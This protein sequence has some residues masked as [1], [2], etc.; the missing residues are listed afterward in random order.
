M[1]IISSSGDPLEGLTAA[2]LD[3]LFWRP[4]RLGVVSAWYGHVPFAQWLMAAARPACLVELGAH[5]GVS[6]I[7]FCD[8][9]QRAGVDARCYAVDTWRG[10]EH[11]GFY[12]D[13]IY[14]DLAAFHDRHF[15]AFSRLM[16]CS[17]DEALPFFA[18]GSID[19]LH[20]DGRHRY[21]DVSHDFHTW[22][23]KLSPRAV[24]L[25]HD[26]N[27]RA[28]D[29]G[30]WRLWDELRGR[31]EHFEFLHSHGLGV[32][33]YGP[34]APEA[35]LALCRS[36]D[37]VRLRARFSLLGE[38]WVQD[39]LGVEQEARIAELRAG[40]DRA[41]EAMDAAHADAQARIAHERGRVEKQAALFEQE[42]EMLF[43][44]TAGLQ[45]DVE[46]LR[47]DLSHAL[48]QLSFTQTESAWREGE[49]A[50]RES[51]VAW[52]LGQAAWTQGELAHAQAEAAW[53]LGENTWLQTQLGQ[54][55]GEREVILQSTAW[56]LMTTLMRAA[57]RVP[58][59]ARRALRGAL[60]LARRRP[61]V[62]APPPDAISPPVPPRPVTADLPLVPRAETPSAA[63]PPAQAAQPGALARPAAKPTATPRPVVPMRRA[64]GQ[65]LVFVS[66][67]HDTPGHDY[68]VLR[69]VASAVVLG[70]QAEA[71]TI[72]A[73]SNARLDGA[74]MVV[75]WRA[76]WSADIDRIFDHCRRTGITTIFDVDDLMFRPELARNVLIDGI[77]SQRLSELD[78]QRFY[79][80]VNQS[81]R[82]ADLCT[83]TTAELASHLRLFK[84]PS[85][86]VPNCWNEET[87]RR[88]RLAVRQRAQAEGDGLVR[89]GY[90][91]GTRTHQKDFAAAVGAIARLLRENPECRLVLFRDPDSGEGIVIADEFDELAEL[92]AQV[93][94]RDK[95]ALVD[96]AAEIARFDINLAP[97]QV[98]NPFC[99]AKSELKYW[100]AA[101]AGVPTVASPTGPYRRAIEHGRTGYLA[102][103]EEEWF[104]ALA[105]LAG[106]AAL[107]RRVAHAAYLDVLWR[108]GPLHHAAALGSMLDQ[109]RGGRGAARAM[110]LDLLSAQQPR[111][112]PHLP[113]HSILFERDALGQAEVTVIV[114]VFNYAHYVR[115][116]LDSVR[117]QTA[118]V[119]DLIVIED[120]SGDASLSV[121]LEW[122][123]AH[124]ERFNR[125]LVVQHT[126]NA[127]LGFG[128]NTGFDLAETPYV[129][130]LDADNTL[131]PDAVSHLSARLRGSGAAFA[132]PT[133][134]RFGKDNLLI[135]DEPFLAARLVSGNF[136]DAMAL[137]RRDA[138]AAAGGYDHVRFGW[139][140]YDFWCRLVELGLWGEHVQE[141]LADYRAHDQSMLHTSTDVKTNKIALIGDMKKRHPWLD[142]SAMTL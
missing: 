91:S 35:V 5:A 123:E 34:D 19:L 68:R 112:A 133:I 115:E 99:E 51:E 28:M 121:V 72:E 49:L 10:D 7:A 136:I 14:A 141:V 30:V 88:S 118:A 130:P 62:P 128:R 15:S 48:S 105:S 124:A 94:W 66:G 129:L 46:N 50:A 83:C 119:L 93:E 89:I 67:E 54:L 114:P 69:A 45:Y 126:A 86:V 90:A 55:Q 122:A 142:M 102:G 20:I 109:A 59:P 120:C 138:W 125:I 73:A 42:K 27:E 2:S 78:V 85:F 96:L 25:F 139:E 38:R 12:D 117:A 140:D 24:V 135:G 70:W 63:P 47:N 39:F 61:G 101:L 32:L 95:V 84:K 79:V 104:A 21:E 36:P 74:D 77:R 41:A 8:A 1:D 26:T 65:R 3:P 134:Q 17:F 80:R 75:I 43:T 132:Y 53:L 16:R 29:F 100:E 11:A 108:F 52:H 6:Y 23:A 113:E 37:T 103:T 98:G 40:L 44:R 110:L 71:M 64:P 107:R 97:L 13:S 92:H 9:A 33:A 57:G 81:V 82:A 60:R 76:T 137:V 56:R 18:D 111:T 22:R 116:A 87:W 58:R 106:D 31:H 127:G 131:R 4:A